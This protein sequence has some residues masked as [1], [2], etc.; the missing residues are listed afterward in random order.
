MVLNA[1]QRGGPFRCT[2]KS[3]HLSFWTV[4]Y[5]IVGHSNQR[6]QEKRQDGKSGTEKADYKNTPQLK[7]G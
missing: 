3:A 5:V 2:L 4:T 7:G 1:G 6:L